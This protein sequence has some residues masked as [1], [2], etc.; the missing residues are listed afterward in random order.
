MTILPRWFQISFL[1]AAALGIVYVFVMHVVLSSDLEDLASIEQSSVAAIALLPSTGQ[2]VEV[3]TATWNE[4]RATL[5]GG[6][7]VSF[8]GKKGEAWTNFCT[9]M[10]QTADSD[11]AYLLDLKTRPS[12]TGQIVLEVQRGYEHSQWVYESYEG[13]ALLVYLQQKFPGSCQSL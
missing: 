4:I 6:E 5:Q 2:R 11:S 7:R 10:I 8:T 12:I 1:T 13:N 9:L 3:A